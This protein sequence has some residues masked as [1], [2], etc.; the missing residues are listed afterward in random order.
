M[1]IRRLCEVF[2]LALSLTVIR[3]ESLETGILNFDEDIINVPTMYEIVF[4][5]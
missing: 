4:I 1:T 5:S 3:N 2:N